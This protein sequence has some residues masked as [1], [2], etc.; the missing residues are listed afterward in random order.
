MKNMGSRLWLALAALAGGAP[1][2]DGAAPPPAGS[3]DDPEKFGAFYD[4]VLSGVTAQADRRKPDWS[5]EA[6][7]RLARETQTTCPQLP[8]EK[9]VETAQRVAQEDMAIKVGTTQEY[10]FSVLASQ[11]GSAARSAISPCRGAIDLAACLHEATCKASGSNSC[12]CMS[13]EQ[14][15]GRMMCQ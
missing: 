13:A 5:Q 11:Y 12:A 10:A 8:W 6:M 4:S 9:I 14:K 3:C 2:A 7:A 1:A 15:K